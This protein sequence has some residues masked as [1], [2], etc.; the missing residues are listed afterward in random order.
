VT[1][2]KHCREEIVPCGQANLFCRGWKH[3]RFLD[4]MPIGAHYCGGRSVNPLAEPE[5]NPLVAALLTVPRR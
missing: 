5:A 1:S 2:C 4:S 3:V